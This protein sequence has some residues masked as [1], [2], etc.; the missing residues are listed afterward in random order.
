M[1]RVEYKYVHYFVTLE[2]GSPPEHYYLPHP[3]SPDQQI[4]KWMGDLRNRKVTNS[5]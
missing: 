5:L 4:E 3:M 1:G 2:E